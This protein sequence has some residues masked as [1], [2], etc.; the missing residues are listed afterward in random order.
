MDVRY[1]TICNKDVMTIVKLPSVHICPY[2][3]KLFQVK[4]K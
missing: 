2:C 1:C 3:K 4:G